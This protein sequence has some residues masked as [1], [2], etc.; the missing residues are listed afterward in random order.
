[1]I[2][3]PLPILPEEWTTACRCGDEQVLVEPTAI[4]GIYAVHKSISHGT[5][6]GPGYTVTHRPSGLAV[7]HV[8]GFAN[9][10]AVAKFLDDEKLLP[11]TKEGLAT[12]KRELTPMARGH[13]ATRLSAIA[14]REHVVVT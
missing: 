3:E 13:I 12:W 14:P 9:A 2:R 1:M 10:M 8:R 4:L 7:W 5:A 11:E 6:V